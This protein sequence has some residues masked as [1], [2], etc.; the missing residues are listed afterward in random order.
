[1]EDLGVVAH[2]RHAVPGVARR[3]AEPAV[4]DPHG[5]ARL[6]AG[7][8]S[9]LVGRTCVARGVPATARV[10]DT[11]RGAAAAARRSQLSLGAPG[12][13]LRSHAAPAK[14][15]QAHGAAA[16]LCTPALCAG[17]R[18]ARALTCPAAAAA[19][20][21]GACE[22]CG[23]G[24]Q[25]DE[26]ERPRASQATKQQPE[27]GRP[28]QWKEGGRSG[29]AK[30]QAGPEHTLNGIHSNVPSSPWS[31]TRPATL[32][33]RGRSQTYHHIMAHIIRAHRRPHPPAGHHPLPCAPALVN[34][35]PVQVQLVLEVHH[36]GP[37][38]PGA[39]RRE[40]VPPHVTSPHLT[41]PHLTSPPF[42]APRLASPSDQPR[43]AKRHAHAHA[44][45]ASGGPIGGGAAGDPGECA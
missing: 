40:G 32:R 16:R 14:V 3:G 45:R 11:L 38:L 34:N 8:R 15:A 19:A 33:A 4:L 42:A 23:D 37:L 22:A 36:V 9:S 44:G 24:G 25:E 41:S 30:V 20:A 7:R 10:S 13:A 43:H 12:R 2:V 1:M 29:V 28:L 31:Y 27:E 21:A 17:G 35:R 26:R 39:P 5:G 18:A 6:E